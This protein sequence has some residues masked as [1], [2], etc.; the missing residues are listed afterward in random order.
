MFKFYSIWTAMVLGSWAAVLLFA[1]GV[2]CLINIFL[3]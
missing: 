2:Y 1:Y 3:N